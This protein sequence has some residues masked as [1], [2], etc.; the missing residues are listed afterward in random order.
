MP[1]VSVRISDDELYGRLR[2]NAQHHGQG[3][4]TL[5]GRLIDE[6]L[7]MEAHPAVMFRD[8]PEGRRAALAAG[9]E[10]VDVIGALIGGDVPV[11]ER[12]ARAAQLLNISPDAVDAALGYYADFTDEIDE[13]LAQRARAAQEAEAAWARQRALL[14][15]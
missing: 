15:S 13:E 7:R 4:S 5:A 2:Q 10:I 11:D 6:G 1:V 12:P 14:E 8:G 3:I 9:P